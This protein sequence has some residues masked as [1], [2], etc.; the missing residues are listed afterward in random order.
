MT[1]VLN[2]LSV[3]LIL[4]GLTFVLGGTVGL[5]RLPDLFSRAHAASKCDSVGAGS[6][7]LALALQGGLA[8]GDLKIVLLVLLALVSA[9]TTAHALARAGYRTGLRAWTRPERE[10]A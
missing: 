8:F 2:V 4:V 9:P 1:L 7:L 5:V 3:A 6:I 10:D